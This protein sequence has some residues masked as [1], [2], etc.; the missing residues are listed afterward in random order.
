VAG[1]QYLDNHG[2]TVLLMLDEVFLMR[3]RNVTTRE[4]QYIGVLCRLTD[5]LR[6]R[7]NFVGWEY[8]PPGTAHFITINPDSKPFRNK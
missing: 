8:R 3:P 4:G 2:S 1:I 6:E 7:G 5:V